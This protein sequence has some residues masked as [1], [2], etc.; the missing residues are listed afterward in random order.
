MK[1]EKPL[2]EDEIAGVGDELI[3]GMKKS[4]LIQEKDD[5]EDE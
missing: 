2:T 1:P 5:S 3:E 4:G